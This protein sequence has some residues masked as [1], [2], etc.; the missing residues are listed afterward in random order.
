MKHHS[1]LMDQGGF[2]AKVGA[3][4]L[5]WECTAWLACQTHSPRGKN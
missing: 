1:A 3:M 2:P 4:L 5:Q